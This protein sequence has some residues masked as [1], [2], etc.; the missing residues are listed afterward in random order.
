ML[1]DASRVHHPPQHLPRGEVDGANDHAHDEGGEC[2]GDKPGDD[3]DAAAGHAG[4]FVCEGL[5]RKF[6]GF[7]ARGSFRVCRARG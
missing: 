4:M 7:C 3:G 2:Y 1:V 5:H 6:R